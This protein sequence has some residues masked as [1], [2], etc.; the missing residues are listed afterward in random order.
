[1]HHTRADIEHLYVKKENGWRWLNQQELGNKTVSIGLK[2]YLESTTDWLLQF[3][4]IYDKQK[5]KSISKESNKFT[6]QI[7]F[8]P[9]EIDIKDRAM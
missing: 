3:V 1:M 6:N 8:T 4:N 2:K 5:K 7:D 9:N